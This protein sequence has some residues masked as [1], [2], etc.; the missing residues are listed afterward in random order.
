MTRTESLIGSARIQASLRDHRLRG[1][2]ARLKFIEQPGVSGGLVLDVGTATVRYDATAVESLRVAGL[3][4]WL[5]EKLLPMYAK[6]E[7]ATARA[8]RI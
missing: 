8:W 1:A 4:D 6:L 2:M 3:T 7:R 5:T